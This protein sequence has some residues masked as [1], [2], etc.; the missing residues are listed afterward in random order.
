MLTAD[1]EKSKLQKCTKVRFL[2]AT[3]TYIYICESVYTHRCHGN[4][5][6]ISYTTKGG[7]SR[8]DWDKTGIK[9]PLIITGALKSYY[10]TPNYGRCEDNNVRVNKLA[11]LLT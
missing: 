7:S 10:I 2:L 4:R 5:R 8:L 1:G 11:L 9:K 3:L 6:K